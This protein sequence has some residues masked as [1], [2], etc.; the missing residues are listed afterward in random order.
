METK[1][2]NVGNKTFTVRE[3][4][5]V[6]VDSIDYND[7]VKSNQTEIMLSTGITEEEYKKLT[8]KERL[9]IR[10]VINVLNGID[11]NEKNF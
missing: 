1:T 4:L 5:A 7:K 3:L 9:E 10:K 2:I 8:F 11:S 6:E